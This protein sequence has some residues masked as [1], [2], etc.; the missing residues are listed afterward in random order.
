MK[1][2]YDHLIAEGK[3]METVVAD[4]FASIDFESMKKVEVKP[5]SKPVKEETK[6][7]KFSAIREIEKIGYGSR[8]EGSVESLLGNAKVHQSACNDAASL[9]RVNQ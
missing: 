1:A 7:E 4:F 2:V 6:A 9:E 3:K 8:N 5:E